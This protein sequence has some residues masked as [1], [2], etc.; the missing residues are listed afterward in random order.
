M[1]HRVGAKSSDS[2]PEARSPPPDYIVTMNWNGQ[3]ELRSHHTPGS[4][5]VTQ[6]YLVKSLLF[7]LTLETDF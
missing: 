4:S 5:L 1:S 7:Q 6:E 2:Q 3:T